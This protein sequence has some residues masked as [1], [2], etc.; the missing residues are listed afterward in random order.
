MPISDEV[1]ELAPVKKTKKT[2]IIL[3]ASMGVLFALAVAFL[4]M[5]LVKPSVTEDKNHVKDITLVSTELF[6]EA[7]DGE[8]K[9]YASI[10]NEYT[11]YSTLTVDN[12]SSTNVQWDCDPDLLEVTGQSNTGEPYL[13]FVP[14]ANMHGKTAK[15]TVRA[16]SQVNEYK[17]VE[18]TIVNQGAEDIRV[19]Q[20]GVR[21]NLTNVTGDNIDKELSITVPHYTMNGSDNNKSIQVRFEQLSK[22]DPST[23]EYAKLTSIET[24]K[25][26]P[27]TDDVTVTSSDESI[28]SI[29]EDSISNEG[30][31]F[32]VKKSSSTPVTVTIKA[33]VYNEHYEEITKTISVKVDSNSALGFVDSMYV[34]NKPI[35]DKDFIK[36][37]ETAGNSALID[38]GKLKTEISNANKA[39]EGI[40]MMSY[41]DNQIV[42]NSDFALVLPYSNNSSITYNDIFKH[43][44]L[45]PLSIQFDGEKLKTDW[46]K[47]IEVSVKAT[48][49]TTLQVTTN[50]STGDVR[51]YPRNVASKV[52]LTFK[53]KKQG[54][55]GA[56]IT[57]PVRI[58]AQTTNVELAYDSNKT[59]ATQTNITVPAAP[60]TPYDVRVNY[61]FTAPSRDNAKTLWEENCLNTAYSLNYDKTEMTVTLKGS[62][63]PIEPNKEQHAEFGDTLNKVPGTSGASTQYSASFTFTVTVKKDTTGDAKLTFIKNGSDIFGTDESTSLKSKDKAVELSAAFQIKESAT[64]AW[65]VKNSDDDGNGYQNALNLVTENGKY[66]GNFVRDE[67]SDIAAKVYVQN[68]TANTPVSIVLPENLLKLVRTDKSDCK[69]EI[70]NGGASDNCVVWS[71]GDKTLTFAGTPVTSGTRVSTITFQVKNVGN[72]SLG[73]FTLEVYVV[74]AVTDLIMVESKPTVQ[75][76]GNANASI[77]L[78]AKDIQ[79]KRVIDS[80]AKNYTCNDA[81]LYYGGGT[82]FE[83]IPLGNGVYAFAHDGKQLYK[84]ETGNRRL[85]VIADVYAY[86]YKKGI[87]FGE[88]DLECLL[89]DDEEY[90]GKCF[91]REFEYKYKTHFE[92][93]RVADDAMLFTDSNYQ[94]EVTPQQTQTG[95]VFNVSVNQSMEASLYVTAIVNI[96]VEGE[97]GATTTEK[98]Y[99]E[100]DNKV[101]S[102]PVQKAT[103]TLPPEI[104]PMDKDE[105]SSAGRYYSVSYRAPTITGSSANYGGAHVYYGSSSAQK[106][107]GLT[108]IVNN[109]TRKISTI[110]LYSDED[111]KTESSLSGKTLLFGGFIN[112]SDKYSNTVYVKVVYDAKQDS[113]TSFEDAVLILPDYLT[114]SETQFNT[115]K[116]VKDIDEWTFT[117]T[118]TLKKDAEIT[119]SNTI[120]VVPDGQRNAGKGA[121]CNVDVQAGLSG[122][123]AKIGGNEVAHITAGSTETHTASFDMESP[124]VAKSLTVSFEYVAINTNQY[125]LSYDYAG[126]GLKVTPPTAASG[127]T[128]ANNIKGATSSFTITTTNAIV[129]GTQKFLITLTDT[130]NDANANNVFK[131]EVTINVTMDIYSLAFAEGVNTAVTVTGKGGSQTLTIPVVYNGG[132]AGV[133]PSAS[134]IKSKNV[135]GVYTLNAE[136]GKYEAFDGIIVTRASSDTTGKTFTV[137]I[138]NGIDRT[139]QYYLRLIYGN[140]T[141]NGDVH[142]KAITINTLTSHIE[143]NKDNS[144]KPTQGDACLEASIVVKSAQDS[145]TLVADVVNDGSNKLESAEKQNSVEYGLYDNLECTRAANGF[146]ISKGIITVT[147]PSTSGTIYYRAK[148]DDA[149]IGA[150]T[151]LIVKIN[152]TVAPATAVISGVDTYAFN[153]ANDTITLYYKDANNYTQVNLTGKIVASTPFDVEYTTE[154]V[155]YSVALK[156]ASDAAYL[157]VNGFEL[158]PKA[159]RSNMLTTIPVVVTA[160]YENVTTDEKVYNVVITPFVALANARGELSL[161]DSASQLIVTPN[162]ATFGGFTHTFTFTPSAAANSLFAVTGTGDEKT[163]K[164]ATG[165]R[166][167]RTSYTFTES[168]SYGYAGADNGGITLVGTFA[169]TATYTVAVVGDYKLTFDLLAGTN[170]ITPYESGNEST[171]YSV[172]NDGLK[173]S[174]RITSADDGFL[175]TTYGATVLPNVVGVGTFSNK[176]ATVTLTSNASGAFTITVTAT[177]G[178]QKYSVPQSYYFMDGA[179]VSAKMYVSQNGADYAA[180]DKSE[181]NI[182]F[183]T[184]PFKFK[185]EID[186]ITSDVK[187]SDIV[188]VVNGDVTKPTMQG[189]GT[190]KRY[191]EIPVTKPTT[192]RVAASVKIGSRTLYLDEKTVKLT[193]TAP[194]FALNVEGGATAVLPTDTLKLSVGYTAGF[195]GT[196]TTTYELQSGSEYATINAT[197]G[198]LTANANVLTDQTVIVR[199]KITVA[200]G[201]YKGTYNVDKSITV[202]GVALPTI[203]WKSNANKALCLD[204]TSEFTYTSGAYT[205]ANGSSYDYASNV[206]ITLSAASDTLTLSTDYTFDAQAGR[207]ALLPT[208]KAKAGGNIKLTVRANITSGAHTGEYVSDVITVRVMPT[209]NDDESNLSIGNA[210]ATYDL[211]GAEFKQTFKPNTFSHADF[212]RATDAYSVVSLEVVGNTTGLTTDGAKLIV[213]SN[214]TS[215]TTTINVKATVVITDGA[216]AGTTIV[217][218]KAI[219]VVAPTTSDKTFEWGD[220]AYESITLGKTDVIG[221]IESTANVTSIQVSPTGE[222]A[223]YISVTDNGSVAP[224]VAVDKNCN[225]YLDGSKAA[226]VIPVDYLVT[227]DNGKVYAGSAEYTVPAHMVVITAKIGEDTVEGTISISS[228]ETLLIGFTCDSGF[229]VNVTA[230]T[231]AASWLT[232]QSGGNGVQLTAGDVT[233][234]QDAKLTLTINIG[235]NTFTKE[236]TVE[237]QGQQ[238]GTQY[239]ANHLDN[240]L[241]Q[242]DKNETASDSYMVQSEW[243]KVNSNAYNYAESVTV[244]VSSGRLSDYFKSLQVH[245]GSAVTSLNSNTATVYFAQNRS[246]A[247]IGDGFTFTARYNTA[248]PRN[249]TT[250]TVTLT[251]YWASSGMNRY[252]NDVTIQYTLRIVGTVQVTLNKNTSDN[253]TVGSY[254]NPKYNGKY[255]TLPTPTRT[256]YTFLGWFTEAENGTRVTANT[257]VDNYNTHTLYAHWRVKT[258]RVKYDPN[259]G[260]VSGSKTITYGQ[261][262]GELD[263]PT[264]VGHNF[265]GW[266]YNGVI[267]TANTIVNYDLNDNDE[268]NLVAQWSV[269]YHTVTL[270]AGAGVLYGDVKT[271]DVKVAHG[272]EFTLHNAIVPTREGY[273]FDGWAGDASEITADVTLTAQ[274]TRVFTVSFDANANGEVANPQSV[275][276]VINGTYTLPE[277]TRNGY[278]FDGWYVS[279]VKQ[280]D[281]ITVTA[282]VTLI[283]Q[284]TPIEITEP[285]VGGED[286]SSEGNE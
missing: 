100:R 194:N 71:N 3:I 70:T 275:Q 266:T 72:K 10:G 274:W 55:A 179:N 246:R 112:N 18:F 170:V 110:G 231:T 221:S 210:A 31:S 44:L 83:K 267:V 152:Y 42:D 76:D 29:N 241:A 124:T 26:G 166:A 74:D 271:M 255:G 7:V 191:W 257:D 264:Y 226:L 96:Q 58:I 4:V 244:S 119:G 57:I 135:L 160:T 228:G 239:E 84:Y 278:Q 37:V 181:Q 286:N 262:F 79:I 259:G 122:V 35:V 211:N 219:A 155:T 268:V 25:N 111:C 133:Q 148:Y 217:G 277:L 183:T 227:L 279:G 77:T 238:T 197:T 220:N 252:T 30:F 195:G 167:E 164:F 282:D 8:V 280:G 93:E 98:V 216:Y 205:F 144:I 89:K 156:N 20:Y 245:N 206:N 192:L 27:M 126:A 59:T 130:Y 16:P 33:N 53:D 80:T 233:N 142:L 201:V 240:V 200:D 99:V 32:I 141:Y 151:P 94:N 214:L 232:V 114:A 163:I 6:S 21:G 90:A 249:L 108:F 250:I 136:T 243:N 103:F 39:G 254:T 237:I 117:C 129:T 67:D 97:G 256:G 204:G 172:V 69:V 182:D 54:S 187:D 85:S 169:S 41:N 17:T 125:E 14:R 168:V 281:S 185:Y 165:T 36:K 12:N 270:D 173:Y 213:G 60:N 207:I 176:T 184:T 285:E 209:M 138:P 118:I 52:E 2:L 28:L 178:G 51:L 202:K 218:T 253:V 47:N 276:I 222:N 162:I 260:S 38:S 48:D 230:A 263:P 140:V 65:F 15:I 147:N 121:K 180:F 273:R 196:V 19:T 101:H 127:F 224:T 95:K 66:A 81:N 212:V 49:N 88:V 13:K 50:S 132:I 215:A 134:V 223:Q 56:S 188:L 272:D 265:V 62:D 106:S 43:I 154:K 171:K 247:Y 269:I 139:T 63:K 158:K 105:S 145:F 86:S 92:F 283:A 45:N 64:K 198:V 251:T 199:A 78:D 68:R 175:T 284:W 157:D 186:G 102:A 234:S 143:F 189:Q 190:N 229:V 131:F 34:F 150:R 73:T 128:F 242:N 258:Y 113:H 248:A 46:Y 146:A 40:K 109:A 235:G 174:V 161:L 91:E 149:N 23:K 1:I 236:Y 87:N 153:S 137:S 5:Y 116:N 11:V 24:S 261:T 61:V 104:T 75:Y 159:L 22:Q 123:I 120:E 177:I 225:L 9:Y 193:A 203:A 115:N 107:Y 82:L 208:A